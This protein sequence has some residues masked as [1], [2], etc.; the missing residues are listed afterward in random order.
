M[1]ERT[2]NILGSVVILATV[3]VVVGGRNTVGV[4]RESFRGFTGAIEAATRPA[5]G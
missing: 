4:I 1:I 5:R 3:A 2:A